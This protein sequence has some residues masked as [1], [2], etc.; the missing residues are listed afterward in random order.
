MRELQMLDCTLRDGGCV[1]DFNFGSH[2]MQQILKGIEKANI[3]VIECGYIDSTYGAQSGRT[4]FCD[5]KVI[6][7]NFIKSKKEN[8]L[9]VAM[10]DYGKYDVNMLEKRRK[11]G[12]D[13]IRLAFHKKDYRNM[14]AVG[15]TII[16][17][18]YLLFIQPMT[19]V[20][21]TDLELIDL[22]ELVNKELG[23]AEAFYIVDSFGE[24]R[25]NDMSRLVYLVDHNLSS[26]M[27]LGFHS[28][29]NLQLS[30]SNAVTFISFPTDRKLI[31]DASIMGMGKGAGNLNTELFAEHLNLFYNKCYQIEPLLE[32]IDEVINQIH[33]EFYWGYSIEFY[34]SSIHHCTP[35]YASHFYKKHMLSVQQVSELLKMLSE[36]K[37]LSFDVNYANEIYLQ[38]REKYFD[39]ELS[40]DNI[41]KVFAGK[42]LLLVAPGKHLY[43]AD[44]KIREMLEDSDIISISLNNY[45]NYK[46]DY[47]FTTKEE[48]YQRAKAENESIIVTSNVCQSEEANVF[49]IDYR[50]WIQ[51][52]A[53]DIAAV[54][55]LNLLEACKI[56]EVY[57]AG[58]DGFSS[59]INENYCQKELRRP[60]SIDEANQRNNYIKDFLN[61]KK[62]SMQITFLT[63]SYYE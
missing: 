17:K 50:K 59:N 16:E 32:T 61:K 43:D 30:Y 31:V 39:D 28:H 63:K 20:R 44:E 19:T 3:D 22:I 14:I 26:S 45:K 23:D 10:I 35:S 27:T 36:E 21:Y 62:G 12:I 54:Y 57:L 6:R 25:M 34:L 48:I 5:E 9:Y 13:G 1:N 51:D 56:S 29:N 8:T 46:T 38:Y 11:D 42:K 58:F 49:I 47:I 24:M 37:K 33:A 40:V 55:V 7:E 4:K 41:K 53:K 60:I 2:D 15:K 18:G 52:D